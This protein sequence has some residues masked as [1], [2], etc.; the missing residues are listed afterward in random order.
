MTDP[1]ALAAYRI[2]FGA[3]FVAAMVECG[4]GLLVAWVL[5]RYEFS[6][7]A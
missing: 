1:F 7:S 5:V 2:S 3:S 4:I 6:A